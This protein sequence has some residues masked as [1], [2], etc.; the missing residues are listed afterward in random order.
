MLG[1]ICFQQK[2]KGRLRSRN[3]SPVTVGIFEYAHPRFDSSGMP[4]SVLLQVM[5]FAVTEDPSFASRTLSRQFRWSGILLLLPV[6]S[7]VSCDG[8]ESLFCFKHTLKSVSVVWN[9]SF[10]S[11][12]LSRQSPWS[13]ILLFLHTHSHISCHSC[14]RMCS[15]RK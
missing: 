2:K 4:E 8:L 11:R 3:T 9:P 12:T 6:H 15:C 5:I 13:G 1:L 10:A 7:H 14:Q